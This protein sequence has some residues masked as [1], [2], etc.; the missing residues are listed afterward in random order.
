MQAAQPHRFYMAGA[1]LTEVLVVAAIAT[2]L[3]GLGLPSFQD[4]LTALRIRQAASS[5]YYDLVLA[6]SEAI[7]RNTRVAICKSAEGLRCAAAG[8]WEHGWIVF[9]DQD[10]SGTRDASE[11]IL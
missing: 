7:K 8:G 11:T 10:N 2:F 1:S 3:L 5:F 6:K 9:V 4:M